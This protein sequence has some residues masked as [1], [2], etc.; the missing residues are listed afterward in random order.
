MSLLFGLNHDFLI[1][2]KNGTF[3]HYFLK[4]FL[5]FSKVYF[6]ISADIL[7]RF[8]NSMRKV[9]IKIKNVWEISF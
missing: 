2:R 4:I 7:N 8:G 9:F 1:I 3:P 5:Q 6:L